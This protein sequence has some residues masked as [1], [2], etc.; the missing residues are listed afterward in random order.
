MTIK[1]DKGDLEV[2]TTIPATELTQRIE[3]LLAERQEHS[4]AI[5]QIDET[6]SGVGAALGGPSMAP[7]ARKSMSAPAAVAAKAP[8]ASGKRRRG[9]GQY[10]LS[11]EESILE[12]VKQQR[13]PTTQDV[14]AHFD[15]EGRSS[16]ADNALSRLVK[17]GRLKRIPLGEGIRGSRYTLP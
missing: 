15:Q 3:Q 13:N 4:D 12:F 6:L 2:S 16:T 14:N 10:A 5:A 11:A 1:G 9:R 17:D 7:L 8:A